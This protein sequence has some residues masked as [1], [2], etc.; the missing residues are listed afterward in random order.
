MV[1]TSEWY[2]INMPLDVIY[3]DG[4]AHC[5]VN[6]VND[7]FIDKIVNHCAVNKLNNRFKDKIVN[8]CAVK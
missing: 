5:A 3:T 7:R 8:H 6:K 4:Y 2:V 1:I